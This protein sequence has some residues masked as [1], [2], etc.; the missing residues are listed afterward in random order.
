MFRYFFIFLLLLIISFE[1]AQTLKKKKEELK[2]LKENIKQQEKIIK[3]KEKEKKI[4]FSILKKHKTTKKKLEKKINTLKYLEI[5]IKKKLLSTQ[6]NLKSVKE[7]IHTLY[8]LLNRELISLMWEDIDIELAKKDSLHSR[9]IKELIIETSKTLDNYNQKENELLSLKKRTKS[10]YF[11]IKKKKNL[12]ISKKKKYDLSIKKLKRDISKLSKEEQKA[13]KL[14][15]QY[16][17]NAKELNDLITK[18][19]LDLTKIN[20]DYKFKTKLIWP[21]KGKIIRYFGIEKNPK[22][23]R[24]TIKSNGIDIQ[25]EIGTAVHAVADG[26]VAFSNVYAGQGKLIII[27]H[28]N[29]YYSL[30]SHNSKLLVSKGEEVKAGQ[31]IALSGNSGQVEQPS[32]HFEIR[33]RGI[34]VDPLNFLK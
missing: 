30:Y 16:E 29:G 32:L 23:K 24:I 11:N 12:T 2:K 6:N 18:L 34:P 33:K 9:I 4:K 22:Y 19:Q 25:A 31:I 27:D 5:K 1:H 21:L 26:I 14:K 13:I 15:E 3:Q 17:K 28:K 20:Y 8:H 10:S 7:N